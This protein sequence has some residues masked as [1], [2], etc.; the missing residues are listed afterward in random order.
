MLHPTRPTS[1]KCSASIA[2]L[3]GKPAIL[4]AGWA[5]TEQAGHAVG[6]Q[7]Q[8]R[9][10]WTVQTPRVAS[11]GTLFSPAPTPTRAHPSRACRGR[12]LH[13]SSPGGSQ[14][15]QMP[16]EEAGALSVRRSSNTTMAWRLSSARARTRARTPSSSSGCR[17]C[18][19]LAEGRRSGAANRLKDPPP[20]K[21]GPGYRGL[22]G[23]SPVA[24]MV[25]AAGVEPASETAPK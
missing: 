7:R 22:R 11:T 20:T 15:S 17:A 3:V 25:E 23:R 21:E 18:G 4:S 5:T 6:G 14:V 24:K 10:I 9:S 12:E 19:H 1:P 13:S 2:S 16:N 8:G